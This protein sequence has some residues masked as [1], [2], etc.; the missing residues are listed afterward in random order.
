MSLPDKERVLYKVSGEA[1]SGE[2]APAELE[3]GACVAQDISLVHK[4]GK[5]LAVVCGAGNIIRGRG[6]PNEQ[7]ALL[8]ASGMMATAVNALVLR[9][10]LEKN[11]T[12]SVVLG[13]FRGPGVELYEIRVAQN[14]LNQGY[15]VILAGG[16]GLPFFSTDT[17]AAV[18]AWELQCDLVVKGTNVGGVY[19]QD[20]N[21][22]KSAKR[23]SQI[24]Y[25]EVI[26]KKLTFMDLSASL[27]LQ[28][29][30]IPCCVF[31]HKSSSLYELLA[32]DAEYSLV[33]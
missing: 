27:L 21:V 7:R 3:M 23:Y 22:S 13:S 2:K 16:L 17:L 6:V 29:S 5:K 19:D 11:K 8:D 18:R 33:Y 10:C 24:S 20:P 26:E 30:N 12:P 32:K 9:A 1:F 31:D 15:V 28:E 4:A 14:Y 25:A